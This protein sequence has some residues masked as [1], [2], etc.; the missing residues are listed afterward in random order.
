MKNESLII[1]IDINNFVNDK[2]QNI[3]EVKINQNYSYEDERFKIIQPI[4][5]TIIIKKI[6]DQLWFNFQVKTKFVANCDRCLTKVKQLINLKFERLAINNPQTDEEIK[7][8]NNKINLFAPIWEEI[9]AKIPAKILCKKLCRGLCPVC[10]VNLNKKTCL[11]YKKN[12][13]KSKNPFS[14]LKKLMKN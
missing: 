2:N 1:I 4:I 7:I 5:G 13:P 12:K 6:K 14:V 11:H 9:I 8:T 10:G 3:F